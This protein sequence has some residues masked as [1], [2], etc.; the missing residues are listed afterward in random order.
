MFYENTGHSHNQSYM[1]A[2]TLTQAVF[3]EES[4]DYNNSTGESTPNDSSSEKSSSSSSPSSSPITG[5][6]IIMIDPSEHWRPE[7]KSP[8]QFRVYTMNQVK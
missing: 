7:N 4:F 6:K 8:E 5:R 1:M 2:T 3:N